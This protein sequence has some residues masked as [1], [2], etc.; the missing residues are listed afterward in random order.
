[1]KLSATAY[2]TFSHNQVVACVV[3]TYSS[4]RRT[5]MVTLIL[6]KMK[7]TEGGHINCG[8]TETKNL[9][10]DREEEGIR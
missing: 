6:T 9:C 3:G 2:E 7:T 10:L 1:M 4:A 5:I 8:R